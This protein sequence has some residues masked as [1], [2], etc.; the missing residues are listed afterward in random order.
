MAALLT[1]HIKSSGT[2]AMWLFAYGSLMNRESRMSTLLDDVEAHNA[3]LP[4]E[5][6]FERQWCYRDYEREQTCLGLVRSSTPS[7]VEGVI[8]RVEDFSQLD[9]REIDYTR[10]PVQLADGT[11]ADTY[12]VQQPL[13]PSPDFPIKERY[14]KLCQKRETS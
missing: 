6:G 11:W 9:Q 13:Q 1:R 12:V 7:A 5:A 14:V 3:T 2:N 10:E 8:L 4:A